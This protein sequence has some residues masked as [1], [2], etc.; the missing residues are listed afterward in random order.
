MVI[1][2]WV[3]S[4]SHRMASG[5]GARRP[6]TVAA[7]LRFCYVLFLAAQLRG[8]EE[9]FEKLPAQALDQ[10]GQRIRQFTYSRLPSERELLIHLRA[11]EEIVVRVQGIRWQ[12]IE[13]QIEGLGFGDSFLVSE[14]NGRHG[15]SCKITPHIQK[16]VFR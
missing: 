1:L 6:N 5:H 16:T 7:T 3:K 15:V 2:A 4:N 13:R 8:K 14:T 10:S 9:M 11:Q 12:E